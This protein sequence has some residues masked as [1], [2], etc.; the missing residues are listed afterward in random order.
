MVTK[1][2]SFEAKGSSPNRS[3]KA[4]SLT[5]GPSSI[6]RF[7]TH[8]RPSEPADTTQKDSCSTKLKAANPSSDSSRTIYL[9]NGVYGLLVLYFSGYN[10]LIS[11]IFF[12]NWGVAHK[13]VIGWEG[14]SL[15]PTLIKVPQSYSFL[16]VPLI[17][18]L[19]LFYY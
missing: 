1:W 12:Q 19:Y 18:F 8:A 6:R 2:F 13:L 4:L 14:V 5:G 17:I 7:S 3:I 9:I 15:T 11:V 16:F 10:I